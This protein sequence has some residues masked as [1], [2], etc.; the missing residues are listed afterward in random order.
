D[1]NYTFMVKCTNEK[2]E[3]TDKITSFSIHITP[4]FYKSWWFILLMIVLAGLLG[5]WFYHL[6]KKRKQKKYIEKTIDYFANSVYGENSVNEI[7]WDIA[8]NCISQLGLEDC[9]V[10]LF[11][12]KKNRLIQKAAYGPKNP[13]GHEIMNTIEIEM[14]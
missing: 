5:W 8:R 13:K 2:G 11:D 12:E 6:Y 3:W 1:G 4:P 7:C 14:V 9:V 10:Y